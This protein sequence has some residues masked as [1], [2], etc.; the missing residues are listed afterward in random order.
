VALYCTWFP[1]ARYDFELTIGLRFYL[2]IRR[3]I[4]TFLTSCQKHQKHMLFGK[5][6]SH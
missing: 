5:C 2:Q 3:P 4:V 1:T 6:H